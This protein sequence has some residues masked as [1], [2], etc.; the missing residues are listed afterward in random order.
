MLWIV[1]TLLLVL[2]AGGAILWPYLRPQSVSALDVELDPRLAEM[3]GRREMLY[4][5]LRDIRFDRQTGKL[6]EED[7]E[8]QT[9]RLKHEAADVLRAIDKLE[10][11]LVPAELDQRIETAVAA[12]RQIPAVLKSNNGHTP[13]A[14]AQFCTQCGGPLRAEDRFCGRCGQP[15]PAP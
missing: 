15:A 5:A 6:S 12:V 14:A 8:T 10:D 9:S 3:Y 13:T 4:Q 1:I 7:Y 11:R 2:A